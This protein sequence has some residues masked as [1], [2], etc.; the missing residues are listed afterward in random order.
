MKILLLA[1][2]KLRETAYSDLVEDYLRRAG[3]FSPVEMLEVRTAGKSPPGQA[4]LQE[5]ERLLKVISQQDSVVVCD[6][7]GR[8]MTTN[9]LVE[10]L[11]RKRAGGGAGRLVFIVGGT[12]GVSE[13]IR[14]RAEFELALSRMTLPHELARVVLAEQIYRALTLLA[15]HPYHRS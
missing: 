6:E 15:N 5:G 8:D 11:I 12:E 3:R 10:F 4:V 2:G 9:Q 13:D 1:V 14:D 7:R